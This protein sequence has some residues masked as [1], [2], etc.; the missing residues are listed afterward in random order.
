[1]PRSIVDQTDKRLLKVLRTNGRITNA[2]L[3]DK[4]A[5]SQ[6][7]CLRRVKRLEAEG[8]IRGYGAHLDLKKMG[9]DITAFV[10]INSEKHRKADAVQFEETLAAIPRVVSCYALAGP[11]DLMLHVV[12]KDIEDYY[13]LVQ[14]LGGLE[15]V[16]DIESTIVIGEIK[17]D[18]GVPII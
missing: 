15:F 17:P 9:W 4:V 5:L 6:S 13:D 10:H 18:R 14:V 16:K 8:V 12:A 7:P 11:W 1:M 2:D 3:A